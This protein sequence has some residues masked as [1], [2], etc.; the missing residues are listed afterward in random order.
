MKKK[1]Q[2][3]KFKIQV[4][5]PI[6]G[7][8]PALVATTQAEDIRD[9]HGLIHIPYPW[10]WIVYLVSALGSFVLF[11]WAYRAWKN[12]RPISLKLPHEIA[13]E[14]LHQARSLMV[15]GQAREFSIT[16]SDIVRQYIEERFHT[17]A[18]LRTTEEFLCDLVSDPSSVLMSH[19]SL[20]ED[21]LK[22]CD[23]V[24]FARWTLS[25][26]EMQ[27][28]Y[29]SACKFIEGTGEVIRNTQHTESIKMPP[30]LAPD[31]TKEATT[32][33]LAKEK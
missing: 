31:L 7:T 5:V 27:L 33:F 4:R 8:Y 6:L 9:I 2:N 11:S 32:P 29:A 20:L 14:R 24:K 28:M 16:I 10:F 21:F 18:P 19:A 23:L 15:P 13:L 17:H 30:P 25:V 26:S 22:H 3:S 1:I 12:R